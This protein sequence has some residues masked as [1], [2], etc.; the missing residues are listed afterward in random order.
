MMQ[1]L[2]MSEIYHLPRTNIAKATDY[3]IYAR[4]VFSRKENTT[5]SDTHLAMQMPDINSPD[6]HLI[7][8][9]AHK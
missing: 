1:F 8:S 3:W 5:V 7:R 9:M 4:K 6:W 2:I